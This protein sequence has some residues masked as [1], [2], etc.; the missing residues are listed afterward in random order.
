MSLS[1]TDFFMP[2]RGT[3]MRPA[4]LQ[5]WPIA[6]R[7]GPP[8]AD[9]TGRDVK[10]KKTKDERKRRAYPLGAAWYCIFV[11]FGIIFFVLS[12]LPIPSQLKR[13]W[14]LRR[15]C[16]LASE[17]LKSTKKWRGEAVPSVPS[18]P[19][20]PLTDSLCMSL[21]WLVTSLGRSTGV[22][23]PLGRDLPTACLIDVALF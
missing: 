18:P 5:A 15:P 11:L 2:D 3:L 19:P 17:Q 23:L 20:P 14:A 12:H 6:S 1:W 22:N 10:R 7:S 21:R 4:D 13:G 8:A 9:L 16:R